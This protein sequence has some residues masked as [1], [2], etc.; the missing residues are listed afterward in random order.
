MIASEDSIAAA[1]ASTDTDKV[2]SYTAP[3]SPMS[4]KEYLGKE[5]E[6]HTAA[7]CRTIS[8]TM[9]STRTFLQLIRKSLQHENLDSTMALHHLWTELEELF[10]M[11][12]ET[13][14]LPI[15]ALERQRDG[16]SLYH[17][18]A[19]DGTI[20]HL[21]GALGNSQENADIQS[22]FNIQTHTQEESGNI[23]KQNIDRLKADLEVKT[24][25]LR[26]EVQKNSD[27]SATVA[28]L[29]HAEH[30][31]KLDAEKV[32]KQLI[33]MKEKMKDQSATYM[34]AS[35]VCSRHCARILVSD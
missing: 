7:L 10:V 29:R 21:H 6:M 12:N 3:N 20:H 35:T 1:N 2:S 11:A 14:A 24:K 23:E 18:S 28:E 9:A 26:H 13:K 31:A 19:M 4:R 22:R 27:L 17:S 16:T 5:T 15:G 8:G 25:A 34:N 30:V 33:A 32:G